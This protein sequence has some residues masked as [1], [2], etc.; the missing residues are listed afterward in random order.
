M[1]GK[2]SKEKKSS[3]EKAAQVARVA[4]VPSLAEIIAGGGAADSQNSGRFLPSLSELGA[5][6]A[7]AEAA[8]AAAAPLAAAAAPLAAAPLA[9]APLAAAPARRARWPAAAIQAARDTFPLVPRAMQFPGGELPYTRNDMAPWALATRQFKLSAAREVDEASAAAAAARAAA[10][11]PRSIRRLRSASPT[12][13]ARN[14]TK[15]LKVSD[16]AEG[17]AVILKD[18]LEE[19]Q[20][21]NL[22]L[23]GE[24][25]KHVLDFDVFHPPSLEVEEAEE[26]EM[27]GVDSRLGTPQMVFPEVKDGKKL[28]GVILVKP[29]GSVAFIHNGGTWYTANPKVGVLQLHTQGAPG[30]RTVPQADYA[31]CTYSSIASR[32]RGVV[33]GTSI[34]SSKNQTAHLPTEGSLPRSASA[35]GAVGGGAAA[36][37]AAAAGAAAAAA[38]PELAEPLVETSHIDS[39]CNVLCFADGFREC[40]VT[41]GTKQL[42]SMNTPNRIPL[43]FRVFET[44]LL[45]NGGV[46]A[47]YL[48]R[49]TTD[50]Q[51]KGAKLQQQVDQFST[52][53]QQLV[54]I[55]QGI[56]QQI[57]ERVRLV[58]RYRE[59]VLTGKRLTN[60]AEIDQEKEAN[61]FIVEASQQEEVIR[62]QISAADQALS[63]LN[64]LLLTH[65]QTKPELEKKVISIQALQSKMHERMSKIERAVLRLEFAAENALKA[66]GAAAGAAAAGAGAAAAAAARNTVDP[67]GGLPLEE[68]E[69]KE[70]RALKFLSAMYIR[71]CYFGSKPM[72]QLTRS[73]GRNNSWGTLGKGG[74]PAIKASKRPNSRRGVGL[75][76]AKGTRA[77]RAL[78]LRRNF[79]QR[80]KK[81]VKSERAAALLAAKQMN[82]SEM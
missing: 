5:E 47:S 39:L 50:Y 73:Q 26:G 18:I 2:K 24:Y 4:S 80:R 30:W 79:T 75:K 54:S 52:R 51:E 22:G 74:E 72:K 32:H 70:C 13:L 14:V 62:G 82:Q 35:G 53:R 19:L 7:G 15:Y 64:I 81:E 16:T 29:T 60:K 57:N 71:Y 17:N 11:A 8:P 44:L 42:C 36:A 43:F 27:E 33:A 77:K 31:L 37:G 1:S 9:A 28:T 6:G 23:P 55:H 41:E 65:V 34:F 25:N 49:A 40:F 12:S 38:G 66:A 20:Y 76:S 45:H 46:Y 78:N 68:D 63:K 69:V 61:R 21:M 59:E 3:G 56:V 10:A 67:L 58:T 48:G